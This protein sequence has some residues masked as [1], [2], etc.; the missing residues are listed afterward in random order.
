MSTMTAKDFQNPLLRALG[1]LTGCK[2]RVAVAADGTYAPIMTLMGI[3]DILVHGTEP[4]SGQPMV[5]RW[6]QWACKNLR[7]TGQMELEGRGQWVLTDKGVQEAKALCLGVPVP[8]PVPVAATVAAPVVR[9]LAPV[10]SDPAAA[11]KSPQ[12][13][14]VAV[15]AAPMVPPHLRD[16]YI[17]GLLL[18]QTPCLGHYS[19]HGGAECVSCPVTTACQNKQ[20]STY[21][22]VALRLAREDAQAAQAAR[23]SLFPAGAVASPTVA[24]K[25]AVKAKAS[26][27]DLSTAQKIMAFEETLCAECGKPIPKGSACHWV[28][29]TVNNESRMLHL[30]C[31]KVAK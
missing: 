12:A 15:R 18:D 25:V 6:I 19:S 13:A 1:D 20:Y 17:L 22:Q 7:K 11:P 23:V 30:D 9:A 2:A 21:S 4:A 27:L 5:Q 8:V 28:D 3:T 14:P 26:T 10:Q 29:D 16:P 31:L 24:A